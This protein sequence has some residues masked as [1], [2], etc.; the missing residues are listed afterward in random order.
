M[1]KVVLWDVDGTLLNFHAAEKVAIRTLFE[2]F[3]FGEC[4][5][6]MLADYAVINRRHWQALE[7][8]EMT[9]PQVLVGRY[10]EF[11]GKY[12]L[13]TSK[14]QDFNDRYQL[15]LGDTIVFYD[16]AVETIKALQAEVLQCAVTN[17]TKIAQDKK[18]T[19]SGL[20]ELFDNV[21][22]SDVIGVEK[23]NVGFFDAVWAEIGQFEP[24]E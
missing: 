15:A 1:I 4:T 3:G 19:N 20:G 11:F 21:F 9:K 23:P 14:S 24:S 16:G 17:G 18:L 13:D 10:R 22:I 7:R 5:D 6:D 2:E 8:G 12:G